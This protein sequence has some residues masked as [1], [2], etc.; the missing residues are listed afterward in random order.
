M[1]RLLF[2]LCAPSLAAAIAADRGGADRIEL[3]T[4]LA[5]GGVTPDEDLLS[6]VI[7]AVTVPVHVLIRPRAG[8]F[9]F[10]S[11]EFAVMQRQIEA[12]KA[13]GAAGVAVGVLLP[14]GRV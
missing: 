11:E 7:A 12:A 4:D 13:A 5:V 6:S 10:S 8:D 3:C 1:K 14:D 9:I 2:E